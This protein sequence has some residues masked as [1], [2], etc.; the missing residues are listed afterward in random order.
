MMEV[1]G[2]A[3]IYKGGRYMTVKEED[4]EKFDHDLEVGRVG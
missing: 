4:Q 1:L 3:E 2:P